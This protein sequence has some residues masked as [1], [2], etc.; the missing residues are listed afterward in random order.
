MRRPVAG[1]VRVL[2]ACAAGLSALA[3]TGERSTI[4]ASRPVAIPA[5][6]SGHIPAPAALAAPRLQAPRP[7]TYLPRVI[8]GAPR[9]VPRA[10]PSPAP[11]ATRRSRWATPTSPLPTWTPRPWPTGTPA[12]WAAGPPPAR[13]IVDGVGEQISGVGTHCWRPSGICGDMWGVPTVGEPL[14]V[15]SP[16]VGRLELQPVEAVT[17]Y[18]MT[19]FEGEPMDG[20]AAPGGR[21]SWQPKHRDALDLFYELLPLRDQD[22]Q[23]ARA[24]GLYVLSVSV[25]WEAL[26]DVNYGF[27]V[28][29]LP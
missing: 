18:R 29:V 25:A 17:Y 5:H 14:R 8:N 26:G 10:T 20:L 27:L 2:I 16:F 21:Q 11:S 9:I 28:E 23:L 19:V 6:I 4:P 13:L 1:G 22:V 7:R 12:T 15:R 3:G 24:P